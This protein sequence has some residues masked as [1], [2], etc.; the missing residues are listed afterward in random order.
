MN[1]LMLVGILFVIISSILVI[2]RTPM[3]A[4]FLSLVSGKLFAEELSLDLHEKI[5]QFAL[6]KDINT[7][8]LLLLLLPVIFTVVLMQGKTPHSKLLINSMAMV[9]VGATL[10]I[11]AD[12]Y[13]NII[14]KLN[15][16]E[17]EVISQYKSYIVSVTA[18]L[19]VLLTWSSAID[20]AGHKKRK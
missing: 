17:F 13:L 15:S 19:A 18:A 3:P 2:L 12:P 8:G 5:T 16:S 20:F 6:I 9:F 10:V 7:A 11:F 14:S 1:T 4:V